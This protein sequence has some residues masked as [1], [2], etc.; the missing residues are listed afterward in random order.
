VGHCTLA[1]EI[2]QENMP[3]I[4]GEIGFTVFLFSADNGAVNPGST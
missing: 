4:P 2:S 3:V 1:Q